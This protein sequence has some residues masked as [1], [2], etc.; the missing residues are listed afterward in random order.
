[1]RAVP[2]LRDHQQLRLTMHPPAHHL[3]WRDVPKGRRLRARLVQTFLDAL[4]VP[5][6][7]IPVGELYAM[8]SWR[9][10]RLTNRL[11]WRV[12]RKLNA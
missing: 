3:D 5:R 7:R 1:M 9:L 2:E 10:V 11:R 12:E 6:S 4:G 8:D